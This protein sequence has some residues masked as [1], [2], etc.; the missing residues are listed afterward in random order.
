MIVITSPIYIMEGL[1]EWELQKN[2]VGDPMKSPDF[3]L[4]M[5]KVDPV[6]ELLE[7]LGPSGAFD[8]LAGQLP[9]GTDP[10]IVRQLKLLL[11]K[12]TKKTQH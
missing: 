12:A 2:K 7:K 6:D 5:N 11:V 8:E 10:E 9:P 3:H 1:N 4:D